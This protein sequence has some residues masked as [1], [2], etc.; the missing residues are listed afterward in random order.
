MIFHGLKTYINL[1]NRYFIDIAWYFMI[2][3]GT[4]PTETHQSKTCEVSDL[5]LVNWAEVQ[6]LFHPPLSS[7]S[8][9]S[10]IKFISFPWIS[11]WSP[12]NPQYFADEV[13]SGKL[14]GPLTMAHLQLFYRFKVVIFHSYISL[15][16][17]MHIWIHIGEQNSNNYGLWYANN[18]L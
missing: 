10:P 5:I 12:W 16:E 6:F 15:P 11:L 1:R 2:L 9:I 18:I 13:P 3:P 8:L 17:G 4:W 14:T 7:I